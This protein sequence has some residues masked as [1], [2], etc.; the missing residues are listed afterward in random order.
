[1]IGPIIVDPSQSEV[2]ATVGRFLVFDVGGDPG[3]WEIASDDLAVVS[4]ERGGQRDGAVFNPGG[5]ALRE[6]RATV[7]LFDEQSGD[8][9][10]FT[11]TVSS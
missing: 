9:L 6:G 7:T 1:M 8:T 10:E 2:A 11:I 5:E 4:V 3:R